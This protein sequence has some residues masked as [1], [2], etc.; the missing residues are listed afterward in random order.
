MEFR[1]TSTNDDALDSR[2]RLPASDFYHA[3]KLPYLISEVFM[4]KNNCL[5]MDFAGLDCHFW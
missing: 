3:R 4:I 1:L 5:A 2:S